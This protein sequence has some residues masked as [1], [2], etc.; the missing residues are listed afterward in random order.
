MPEKI[1]FGNNYSDISTD[2]A[3]QFEFTCGCCNTG[4]RSSADSYRAGQASKLLGTA[5]S[6]FGGVFRGLS[7]V[8][9]QVKDAS[10]K[11]AHDEA[12]EKA[13]TEMAPVFI[14]CPHCHS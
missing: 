12:F 7:S 3:F 5:S 9:N 2:V 11:N 1:K 4:Y 13:L 6:L 14:Q 10:W 8:G